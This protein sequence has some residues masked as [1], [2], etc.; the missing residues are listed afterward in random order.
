MRKLLILLCL[1]AM[2]ISGCDKRNTNDKEFQ[3]TYN[4]FVDSILD[5]NG[6][7]STDIPFAHR[8]EVEK[9]DQDLYH[10]RVIID[11]PRIAMYHI[12]MMVVDKSSSNAYPFIGLMKDEDSVNMIP[13]QENKE[14]NFVQ[15]IIL[16]GTSSTPSFT[17]LVQVSWKDYAQI[18]NRT[19]FFSYTYD[20]DQ[21]QVEKEEQ[22]EEGNE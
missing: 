9:D 2:S 10:Y 21:A 11:Q 14:K 3:N 22:H 15:G 18:N 13:N 7:D 1:L 19:V 12:Q 6:V 16:E 4:S 17:L 20:Y 5:N 8:L